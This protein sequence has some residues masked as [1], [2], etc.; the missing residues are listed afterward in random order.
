MAYKSLSKFSKPPQCG[1]LKYFL[2]IHTYPAKLT[3]A[4]T[5]KVLI[6]NPPI[7][8]TQNTIT[9]IYAER[10]FFLFIIKSPLVFDSI[11]Y[12]NIEHEQQHKS[13][14]LLIKTFHVKHF[15][16]CTYSG[17]ISS[18]ISSLSFKSYPNALT[19]KF[20]LLLL[21]HTGI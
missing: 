4:K 21:K 13:N 3:I 20:V 6:K 2:S 15:P 16:P 1:H 17:Q 9:Q 10:S 5:N 18:L 14:F 11:L 7:K 19:V 8:Q 12:I